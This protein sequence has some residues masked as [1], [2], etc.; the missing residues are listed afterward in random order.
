M[1]I[2]SDIYFYRHP[3][4]ANCN[5]Y[6]FRDG[7]FIDLIDTG[8]SKFGILRWLVNQMENDGLSP[9]QVR[10]VYHT[11]YHFDHT[12][13]N[14][15]FEKKG[16]SKG[17][18]VEFFVPEPDIYRTLPTYN[19]LNSNLKVLLNTLPGLSMDRYNRL[20]KPFHYFLWP[21]LISSEIPKNVQALKNDEIVTLGQRKARVIVTGGHTEGHC[22]Y[23]IDDEDNILVTGDHDAPN[24]FIVDWGKMIESV[25]IA[26]KINPD[27]VFIGHNPIKKGDR[28]HDFIFGYRKQFH[29]LI[30]NIAPIF[31]PGREVNITKLIDGAL[32]YMKG[33]QSLRLFTFMRLFIFLRHFQQLGLVS[34]ELREGNVFFAR[35]LEKMENFDLHSIL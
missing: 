13:A 12:Q 26:E 3:L 30:D 25:K 20:V 33:F 27:V 15:Y 4:G 5:V 17:N 2:F 8:V 6:A 18:T 11:H 9:T 19:L 16:R 14:C 1:R 24:E 31:K 10:K 21:K 34:L 22:F 35:V 7:N 29:E 28:A 23:Y 32:G